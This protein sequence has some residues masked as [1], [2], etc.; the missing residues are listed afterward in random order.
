M[1]NGLLDAV[2]KPIPVIA[3][4]LPGWLGILSAYGTGYSLPY[5]SLHAGRRLHAHDV[6]LR[7][8]EGGDQ[9]R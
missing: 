1:S 2:P 4:W 5:R 3:A 7:S 9:R 8:C 6:K